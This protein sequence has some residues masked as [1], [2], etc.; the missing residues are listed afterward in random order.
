MIKSFMLM[1]AMTALFAF[2]GIA[3]G[4]LEGMI[5]ALLFAIGMNAFAWY[6]SDKNGPSD[7]QSTTTTYLS[8]ID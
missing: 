2:A 8:S 7:V 5:I 4:G 1:A 6:N 3:M